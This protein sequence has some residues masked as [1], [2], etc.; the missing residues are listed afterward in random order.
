M[1]NETK[2]KENNILKLVL[3]SMKTFPGVT[4]VMRNMVAVANDPQIVFH[5]IEDDDL[6]NIHRDFFD[7]ERVIIGGWNPKL[8]P[9][10]CRRR[11]N[12][13]VLLCS[14]L[15]QME[16]SRVEPQFLNQIIALKSA[17][18]VDSVIFGSPEVYMAYY[19][20]VEDIELMTYPIDM[21]EF[22]DYDYSKK[23]FSDIGLFLPAHGRKNFMNQI[24]GTILADLKLREDKKLTSITLKTN[25]D[26]SAQII[27]ID[28][29]GWME[30]NKYL[31]TLKKIKLGLHV[32]FT[33]SFGY[34]AMDY[35]L[36][37]V[38]VLVSTTVSTNL[39]LPMGLNQHL[40]VLNHDSAREIANKI[41]AIVDMDEE[42]YK[43]LS[44]SC[45]V[46]ARNLATQMNTEFLQWLS[47]FLSNK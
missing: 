15:G 35:L 12:V 24:Y 19:Y 43:H 17:N 46:H 25:Q 22:R 16:L 36:L 39:K 41:V 6:N 38:P 37:G 33:E 42:E 45:R 29:L 40:L 9:T 4:T 13:S 23:S 8:Y 18:H 21:N 1:S 5:I 7:A 27:K 11:N 32:T 28:K 10:L 31:K 26:V 14:S 47:H 2:E 44:M 20:V 30:R 34:A 3:L